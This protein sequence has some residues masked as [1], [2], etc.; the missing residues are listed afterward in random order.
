M[1]RASFHTSS[2]RH[3]NV[4]FCFQIQMNLKWFH[5]PEK[6]AGAFEKWGPEHSYTANDINFV[7]L[8]QVHT[9]KSQGSGQ[10][11]LTNQQS[12]QEK[13]QYLKSVSCYQALQMRYSPLMRH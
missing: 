1:N 4:L 11:P 9:Q 10:W 2:F 8:K 12:M 6:F 13:L 7:N 3:I 5:Q